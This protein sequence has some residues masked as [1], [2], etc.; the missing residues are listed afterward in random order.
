MRRI[1][2]ILNGLGIRKSRMCE[3]VVCVCNDMVCVV[4][5]FRFT[6]DVPLIFVVIPNDRILVIRRN[7]VES[8][9]CTKE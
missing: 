6:N 8:T 7:T 5:V 3:E 1:G 4:L 9:S 2:L